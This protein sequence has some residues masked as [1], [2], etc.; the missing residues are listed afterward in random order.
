M[1]GEMLSTIPVTWVLRG[2][3]R[4]QSWFLLYAV[5]SSTFGHAKSR[6]A[7]R[8]ESRDL[9]SCKRLRLLPHLHWFSAKSRQTSPS[10]SF[11]AFSPPLPMDLGAAPFTDKCLTDGLGA[12]YLHVCF[13]NN[14][15]S[16]YSCHTGERMS[17]LE[18]NTSTIQH[19]R[20]APHQQNR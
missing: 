10:E 20:V 6:E 19:S 12:R 16:L 15:F 18:R 4:P 13:R 3:S 1:L 14:R 5:K 2:M 17:H 7:L 8:G 9:S 11:F